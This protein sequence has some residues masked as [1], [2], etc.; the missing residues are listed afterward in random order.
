MQGA[1][2]YRSE[3]SEDK[4]RTVTYK[5]PSSLMEEGVFIA[6]LPPDKVITLTI[7]GGIIDE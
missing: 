2:S 1:T 7:K 5:N 4:R 3:R 6:P